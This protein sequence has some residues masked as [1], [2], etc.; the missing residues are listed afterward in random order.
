M[1]RESLADKMSNQP[2]AKS[3]RCRLTWFAGLWFGGVCALGVVGYAIRA[4][5]GLS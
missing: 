4:W 2:E 1:A 3:L 5:L